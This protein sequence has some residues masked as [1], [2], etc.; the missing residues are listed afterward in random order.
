MK[1]G[2]I[3]CR[4]CNSNIKVDT[5]ICPFCRASQIDGHVVSTQTNYVQKYLEKHPNGRDTPLWKREEKPLIITCPYCN[6]TNTKKISNKSKA[7][8]VFWYG[9]FAIG[10]VSKQWHCNNCKSDF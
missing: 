7:K 1:K 2:Q 4:R 3:K 5:E 9:I 6:S 8:N 10:K